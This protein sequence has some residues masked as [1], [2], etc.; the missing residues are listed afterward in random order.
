VS[1]LEC[2]FYNNPDEFQRL[3]EKKYSLTINGTETYYSE[4]LLNVVE[5][6]KEGLVEWVGN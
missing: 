3:I 1:Y 2:L 4:R 6:L 5:A